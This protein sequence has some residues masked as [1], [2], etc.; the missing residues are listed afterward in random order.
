[1]VVDEE[2]IALPP[3]EQHFAPR[4]A[5]PDLLHGL[6]RD[7]RAIAENNVA[8]EL[9]FGKTTP[10]GRWHTRWMEVDNVV[11]PRLLFRRRM[12]A[13]RG[14]RLSP[15][16]V[17]RFGPA[18]GRTDARSFLFDDGLVVRPVGQ[19]PG[20][21][22]WV[23]ARIEHTDVVLEDPGTIATVEIAYIC[24]AGIAKA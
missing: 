15:D 4:S 3:R 12:S 20:H 22:I 6:V 17:L 21:A 10:Y 18:D 11:K 2:N 24:D 14:E 13:D 7:R 8:G 5:V 19:L 23:A 1:D 16:E 9:L